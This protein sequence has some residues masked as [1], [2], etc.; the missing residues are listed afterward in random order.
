MIVQASDFPAPV[1]AKMINVI[2]IRI[3]IRKNV[4]YII[5]KANDNQFQ[6]RRNLCR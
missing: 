2:K 6:K 1:F 5:E 3:A 4:W